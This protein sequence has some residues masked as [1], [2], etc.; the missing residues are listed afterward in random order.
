MNAAREDERLRKRLVL[1][2]Q[3]GALGILA[4][5]ERELKA[6]L[7]YEVRLGDMLEPKTHDVVYALAE[8]NKLNRQIRLTRKAISA[9][10]PDW[11]N[12]RR[13]AVTATGIRR[14]A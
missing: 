5:L 11:D 8:V 1:S 9:K 12:D 7:S 6:A 2:D 10:W 3:S 14:S 13:G 4:E